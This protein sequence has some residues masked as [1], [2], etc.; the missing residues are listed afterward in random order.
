M[1]TQAQDL[2]TETK[3]L[4]SILVDL[5][6]DQFETV[7]AFKG[8]TINDIITHIHSGNISAITSL[9]DPAAYERMKAE[10]AAASAKLP[11]S[12]LGNLP[13]QREHIGHLKHRALFDAW[14][15]TSG[16]MAAAFAEA[17]PRKRVPWGGR[18]MSAR[19][20]I[21]ARLMEHWAH[22]QAMYDLLGVERQHTDRLSHVAMLCV[23]TFGWSFSVRKMDVPAGRPAVNLVSPSAKQWQW[24]ATNDCTDSIEGQAAEFCQVAAQTRNIKD[25]ALRVNGPT[26]TLWMENAQCFAGVART[27]PPPGTRF[28]QR[29]AS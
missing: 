1:L 27:P 6:D 5:R 13:L 21:S 7:T 23:N 28:M 14:V 24:P 15:D 22:G 2:L 10:R 12:Q 17:D 9:T 29:R 26:S 20:S 4:A 25:T 19:S 16:R 3:S 11:P 8:W 18:D